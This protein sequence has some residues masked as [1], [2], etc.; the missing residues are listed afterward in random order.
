MTPSFL[1]IFWDRAESA[2]SSMRP[3]MLSIV[4]NGLEKLNAQNE[5]AVDFLRGL[6]AR[7]AMTGVQ[8]RRAIMEGRD[9]F[10]E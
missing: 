7:P 9:A 8:A 3:V 10:R 6:L 5:Q 4:A 2:H 1:E